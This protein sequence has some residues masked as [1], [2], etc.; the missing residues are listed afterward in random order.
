MLGNAT[1]AS[2]YTALAATVRVAIHAHLWDQSKG[3]FWDNTN[4]HKLYPQ[5]GNSL[6]IW[7]NVTTPDEAKVGVVR[8]GTLCTRF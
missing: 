8:A 4:N 1:A 3:A 7:F 6:A 2:S 5:D